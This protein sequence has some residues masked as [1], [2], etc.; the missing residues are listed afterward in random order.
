M[1]RPR[2]NEQ[3]ETQQSI[4]SPA[5]QAKAGIQAVAV[6][7]RAEEAGVYIAA[8][9]GASHSCNSHRAPVNSSA[10]GSTCMLR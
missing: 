6:D 8:S 1:V 2:E 5:E 9:I 10:L 4:F 3:V 7:T